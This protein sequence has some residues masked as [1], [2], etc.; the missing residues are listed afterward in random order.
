MTFW[1]DSEVCGET[2]LDGV[3]ALC[4]ELELEVWFVSSG[5]GAGDFKSRETCDAEREEGKE[6]REV[7]LFTTLPF[8]LVVPLVGGRY[9]PWPL[10][11][12]E[13]IAGTYM[14]IKRRQ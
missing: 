12:A 2:P 10:A 5:G 11:C 4:A 8:E 13:A 1:E 3:F 7:R 9:S 6:E 14:R